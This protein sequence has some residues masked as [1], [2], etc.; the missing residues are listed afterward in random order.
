MIA[1]Y[2]YAEPTFE[3]VFTAGKL[4]GLGDPSSKGGKTAYA[5]VV[6]AGKKKKI[7]KPVT[8]AVKQVVSCSFL[9]RI[10]KSED[11]V[12]VSDTFEGL[13]VLGSSSGTGGANGGTG[14]TIGQKWKGD[15]AAAGGSKRAT[16]HRPRGRCSA[17]VCLRYL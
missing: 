5:V 14:P 13:G 6:V 9:H 1:I 17:R 7:E 12:I 16:L 10:R 15:I 4:R 3:I 11:Y 2:W 8:I